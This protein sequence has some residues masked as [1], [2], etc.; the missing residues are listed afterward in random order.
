[1]TGSQISPVMAKHL[2]DNIKKERKKAKISE[3]N[4]LLEDVFFKKPS[5]A[6]EFVTGLS[7]NGYESWINKKGE[8]L[9]I[10]L[11]RK[12]SKK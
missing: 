6:A 7:S 1:M 11:N 2:P 5:S 4:I 8:T 9:N 3:E 10:F 12:P